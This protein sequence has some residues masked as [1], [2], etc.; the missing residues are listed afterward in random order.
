MLDAHFI[1][2]TPQRLQDIRRQHLRSVSITAAALLDDDAFAS[3]L[4]AFVAVTGRRL[5]VLGDSI[6]A[7]SLG[8]ADLL[9][10]CLDAATVTDGASVANMAVSGFTTSETIPL[11]DLVVRAAPTCVLAMLG[12]NDGRRQGPVADVRTVT[13][14]ETRRNLLALRTLTEVEAQARFIAITPPPMN[15]ARYDASTPPG[16]PVRFSS[17]D[18]ATTLDAVRTA[19]PD[20]VDLP[21]LLGEEL[22][23]EFWLPDGLH[24]SEHGQAVLLRHVVRAVAETTVRG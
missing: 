5:V 23:E 9:S 24:P 1:G 12:T 18:L 2:C 11:F 14:D 4:S 20:V 16:A 6:T 21:A 15:Q 22:P 7:D 17:D 10:A 19:V 3:D 8:W 13:P